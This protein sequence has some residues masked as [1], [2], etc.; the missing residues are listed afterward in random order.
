MAE[1]ESVEALEFSQVAN[2][3]LVCRKAFLGLA[4]KCQTA[5]P[6]AKRHFIYPRVDALLDAYLLWL[7]TF[8][9]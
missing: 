7:V 2:Y 9:D 8:G 3:P 5:S 6:G 1:E 4:A